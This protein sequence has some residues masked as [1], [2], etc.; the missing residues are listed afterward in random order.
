M[1]IKKNFD[2]TEYNSYKIKSKVIL[3][4]FP[5]NKHEISEALITYRDSIIVGGGNNI[6]LAKSF[7]EKPMIFIRDNFS[8]YKVDGNS[9]FVDSGLPMR[10]LSK[11]AAENSLK[12][13]ECFYDI[14][15]TVGGGLAMNA[16]TDNCLI[17]DH[18]I[19]VEVFN[20]KERKFIFKKKN[21][22]DFGYR[23]SIFKNDNLV[24]V[25]AEFNLK[26]GNQ[27]QIIDI[28]TEIRKKR[29]AKQPKN[30]PNA[31]SVFKRPEGYYVG[32]IIQEL[33]LKGYTIG[34]ARI[35]EKHAGFIIN[36]GNA[37]G[38]DIINLINNIKIKVFTKYNIDLELE[39]III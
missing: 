4:I 19:T 32:E 30:F 5:Q 16:G 26:K 35:S 25:G 20:R 6:I 3:A 24:I 10:S 13:F 29:E 39:Q 27:I 7:Y 38:E 9:I 18:L 12:G 31:G 11:I 33:G 14:P 37:T 23:G 22:C 17:S 15:G 21:Q 36:N 34:G 2:L 28:M 1:I 8:N